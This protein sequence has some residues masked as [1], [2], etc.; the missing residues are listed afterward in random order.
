MGNI[1][2]SEGNSRHSSNSSDTTVKKDG[3]AGDFKEEIRRQKRKGMYK[4]SDL[5]EEKIDN[6]RYEDTS[7]GDCEVDENAGVCNNSG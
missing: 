1:T 6:N 5:E 7:I 3:G 4:G 2:S